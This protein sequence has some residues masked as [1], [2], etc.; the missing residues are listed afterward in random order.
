MEYLRVSVTPRCNLR[1]RYCVPSVGELS[2]RG[3]QT[4]RGETLPLDD[5]FLIVR[6]FASLGIRK[7]RV[8]GGEPLLCPG[9]L[10][11]VEKIASL[12]GV[13]EVALTTNGILLPQMARELKA[14]GLKR[15]NLSIDSL[16]EPKYREITGG[17]TLDAVLAAVRAA[18]QAGLTPVKVNT[19]LIR[20]FNDDEIAD[21]IAFSGEEEVEV[22]F[23]EL[24]PIGEGVKWAGKHAMPVSEILQRFPQLEPLPQT[25]PSATARR[26][27]LPGTKAVVGLISPV[28]CDFCAACDRLRLSAQG[29]LRLCL[30]S[31]E[32]TDLS[33]AAGD[34]EALSRLI[35][36]AV[37]RKPLRHRLHEAQYV[38]TNMISIGG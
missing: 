32:E 36:D 8:T 6:E 28:S 17:G 16:R 30:H 5:L 15:I 37:A 2:V 10:P 23:I 35:R 9:L 25:D 1:C 13:E 12:G 26:Y 38:R 33:A 18:K 21:F 22:R 29:R 31:P 27:R 4:V 3:E 19:V 11:F 34:P 24:M 20:G 7:I 14:A